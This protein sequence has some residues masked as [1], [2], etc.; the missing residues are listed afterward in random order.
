MLRRDIYDRAPIFTWTKGR[1][2]LL[3]DSAHAMQARAGR[4]MRAQLCRWG[5]S[6][7]LRRGLTALP[8]PPPPPSCCAAQPG[9]GR[10]HGDRGR[11][12]DGVGAG[13]GGQGDGARGSGAREPRACVG[14]LRTGKQDVCVGGARGGGRVRSKH[15][16]PATCCVS[17]LEHQLAA[18][19]WHQAHV[20]FL[21]RRQLLAP[22]PLPALPSPPSCAA[23]HRQGRCSARHG[24]LCRDHGLHVQGLPGRGAGAAREAHAAAHP[25]PGPHHRPGHPQTHHGTRAQLGGVG[26]SVLGGRGEAGAQQAHCAHMDPPPRPLPHPPHTPSLPC[27]TGCWAGTAAAWRA[28]AAWARAAWAT[29][30]RASASRSSRCSC[31]TTQPSSAPCARAGCSCLIAQSLPRTATAQQSCTSSLP[32]PRARRRASRAR[33]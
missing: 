19:R 2:A 33:A 24:T 26:G 10:L 7:L 4:W 23:A 21:S 11:M 6:P 20:W 12:P 28:A 27:W 30:P 8:P 13:G 5:A 3:G 9:P 17:C 18:T 16:G 31:A 1:V 15:T 25:P 22:S 32:R 14:A 29:S